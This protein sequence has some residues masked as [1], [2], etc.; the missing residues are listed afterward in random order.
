M[1]DNDGSRFV[2]Q[3]VDFFEDISR[4]EL[5]L[6][7]ARR[8]AKRF[9][10]KA[11][12]AALFPQHLGTMDQPDG[13][14]RAHGECG[15]LITF[16]LRIEDGRV[17]EVTFTTDGCDATI[18]SGETLA[19][20]ATGLSLEEAVRIT[21]VELLKAL[22]GIPPNHAHCA[23]LAVKT[24]REALASY[25]ATQTSRSAQSLTQSPNHGSRRTNHEPRR[26]P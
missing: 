4:A 24:L 17:L 13:Y 2:G 1:D 3:P 14:A 22:D 23:A 21:P 11:L 26:N 16:Y 9:S 19:A 8:T 12:R 6:E 7:I 18:A 20:M 5:E 10:T 15:D 25:T